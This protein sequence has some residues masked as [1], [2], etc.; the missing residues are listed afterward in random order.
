MS[1]ITM[2]DSWMR[3]AVG[4]ALDAFG[5]VA[6]FTRHTALS[7]KL[8]SSMYAEINYNVEKRLYGR[9]NQGSRWGTH[10]GNV[11]SMGASYGLGKVITTSNTAGNIQLM[12]AGAST[13]FDVNLLGLQ[14]GA[15]V[16]GRNA[17]E[18]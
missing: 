8:M 3:P 16:A 4:L 9:G 18:R 5:L 17:M 11:V 1:F 6:N 13:A 7:H 14:K 15:G 12:R 2:N 10:V